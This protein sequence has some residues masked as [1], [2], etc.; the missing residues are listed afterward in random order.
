MI[1]QH[2]QTYMCREAGSQTSR[3]GSASQ[4]LIVVR[5]LFSPLMSSSLKTKSDP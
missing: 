3:T 2:T 5:V 4:Q 1:T